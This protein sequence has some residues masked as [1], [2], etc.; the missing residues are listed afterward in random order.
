MAVAHAVY[1]VLRLARLLLRS[2]RFV[3]Q[4]VLHTSDTPHQIALGTGVAMF[5]ALL[6]LVGLQTVIAIAV[7]AVVRANKAVCVP[8]VWIT[9]PVTMGP[10]YAGCYALGRVLTSRAQTPGE[11]GF[12][13]EHMVNDHLGTYEGWGRFIDPGF[14]RDLMRLLLEFGVDLWL[15]C[16]LVGGVLA[17]I[18]YF[19]ARWGVTAFRERHRQRVLRRNLFRAQLKKTRI[20]ATH[21]SA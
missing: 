13:I 6:P 17:I 16:A 21:E 2:R 3:T 20:T 1:E 14:W 11:Q 10:I 9:N 4:K 19:V 5:V 18:S 12:D 7:A 8:I 15:G